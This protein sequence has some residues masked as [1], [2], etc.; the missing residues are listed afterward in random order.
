M[1]RGPDFE[2]DPEKQ[3]TASPHLTE[4]QAAELMQLVLTRYQ[5]ERRQMPRRVV[6]HKT[7]RYWPAER[8]GF[9]SVL[10]GASPS[11]TSWR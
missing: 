5:R 8:D 6:V 7:S 2:W 1:L 11:T 3:G 9:T 4:Y 10:R